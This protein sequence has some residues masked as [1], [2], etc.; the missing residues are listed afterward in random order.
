MPLYGGGFSTFTL[1]NI[2]VGLL[3]IFDVAY[4]VSIEARRF[5]GTA[6]IFVNYHSDAYYNSTWRNYSVMYCSYLVT[7]V[8]S[9]AYV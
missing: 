1:P 7:A 8:V 4:M 5:Y 2:S 6:N 3:K 9:I